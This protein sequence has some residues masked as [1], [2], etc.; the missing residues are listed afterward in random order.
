MSDIVLNAPGSVFDGLTQEKVEVIN[1]ALFGWRVRVYTKRDDTYGAKE[2]ARLRDETFI[3]LGMTMPGIRTRDPFRALWDIELQKSPGIY[4]VVSPSLVNYFE[5]L[6]D[7]PLLQCA[8]CLTFR[9]RPEL[10]D[11]GLGFNPDF[12]EDEHLRTRLCCRGGDC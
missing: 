5:L 2:R 3:F 12:R 10:R 9:R 8:D 4:R 1:D 11:F 7:E 6:G